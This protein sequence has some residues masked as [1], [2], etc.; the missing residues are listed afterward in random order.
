MSDQRYNGWH[1][2]ETWLFN[3]WFD[4]VFSEDAEDVWEQSD[5]DANEAGA[6]LAEYIESFAEE[7]VFSEHNSAGFVSDILGYA[8]QAIDY[9]EIADNYIMDLEE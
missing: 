5:H 4:N 6:Q 9:R 1:N 2:Y 8:Q 3:L 7:F